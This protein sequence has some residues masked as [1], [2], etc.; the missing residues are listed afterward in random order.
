MGL[1]IRLINF[2]TN[3]RGCLVSEHSKKDLSSD[4][5]IV[6]HMSGRRAGEFYSRANRCAYIEI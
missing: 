1:W 3:A 6:M 4:S 5:E 2:E